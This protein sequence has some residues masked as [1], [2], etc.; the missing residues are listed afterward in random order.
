MTINS[1]ST[2]YKLKMMS[3]EN[4]AGSGTYFGGSKSAN[5][6]LGQSL[7]VDH[8]VKD[9]LKIQVVENVDIRPRSKTIYFQGSKNPYKFQLLHGSGHFAVSSND[10]ELASIKAVGRDVTI[11]PKREG[12]LMITV[13]DIEIPESEQVHA[14]LH[15]SDVARL[16][17]DT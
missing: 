10:T 13:K 12:S 14:E 8:P 16:E 5:P 4:D 2:H 6:K 15:V 11:Y 3:N 1:A 7:M 9:Q 17:L